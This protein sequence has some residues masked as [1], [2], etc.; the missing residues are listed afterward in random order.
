[1][2][3][4]TVTRYIDGVQVESYR[5]NA[6]KI[7]IPVNSLARNEDARMHM[8]VD[9][10]ASYGT[11]VSISWGIGG[12]EGL[13]EDVELQLNTKVWTEILRVAQRRVNECVELLGERAKSEVA[14]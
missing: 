1:M 13:P 11:N 5:A 8:A 4:E 7:L 12:G 2:N 10:W 3:R 14:G 9:T 6:F